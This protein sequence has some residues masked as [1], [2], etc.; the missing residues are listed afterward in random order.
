LLDVIDLQLNFLEGNSIELE[1]NIEIHK[2]SLSNINKSKV[3]YLTYT[4]IIG[5]LCLQQEDILKFTSDESLDVFTFLSLF[6]FQSI[7]EKER[8]K[9]NLSS[10]NRIYFVDELISVLGILFKDTITFNKDTGIFCIGK[11]G[12]SLNSSNFYD[13]QSIIKKRNCIENI[14]E[15]IDNPANEMARQ[16][17]AKQKKARE[18]LARAKAKENDDDDREPLTIIDLISI[19][20]EAEH[21]KLEEVFQYDIFQFNNQFN[22]MKIIK[23][24]E[25]NVQALIAGAS[26]E[27]INLQHWMSKIKTT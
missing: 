8:E 25:I 23:D 10:I 6:T 26:G 19:F 1:P 13:F 3:G 20:A 21:M 27:D 22:R 15:D 24:Y 12:L 9:Y 7:E 11:K 17:L 14:E 18:K 2:V 5:M 16:I 4:N